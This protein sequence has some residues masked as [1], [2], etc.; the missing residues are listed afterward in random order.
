MQG[1]RVKQFAAPVCL[2]LNIKPSSG[3]RGQMESIHSAVKL[4]IKSPNLQNINPYPFRNSSEPGNC[5]FYK[6][7]QSCSK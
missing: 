4:K 7:E 6:A 3:L 5:F 1:R 2:A